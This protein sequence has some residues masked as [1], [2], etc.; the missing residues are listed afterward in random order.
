MYLFFYRLIFIPCLFP[1]LLSNKDIASALMI[2]VKPKKG[3]GTFPG[4]SCSQNKSPNKCYRYNKR[5]A[6]EVDGTMAFKVTC[7]LLY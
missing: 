5:H 3:H 7:K 2:S 6:Y 1:P 4:H